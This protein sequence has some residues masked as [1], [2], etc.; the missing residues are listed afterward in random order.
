[1]LPDNTPIFN[2]TWWYITTMQE[3]TAPM[4]HHGWYS[5]LIYLMAL[6]KVK[7]VQQKRP[8]KEH[9][10]IIRGDQ[11]IKKIALVLQEMNLLMGTLYANTLQQQN[12][13]GSF[14]LT[15]IF[16]GTK[17]SNP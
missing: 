16:T 17:N 9:G 12:I 10:A 2:Q 13:H 11:T 7:P 5:I 1:M 3:T 6:K 8:V 4:N 14:F 15:G